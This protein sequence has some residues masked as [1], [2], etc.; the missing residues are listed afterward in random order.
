MATTFS[1]VVKKSVGRG[2]KT[3]GQKKA[4]RF[5]RPRSAAAIARCAERK[6]ARRNKQAASER[7]NKD[8]REQGLPT[9]WEIAKSRRHAARH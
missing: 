3:K 4:R 2:Q 1:D 6:L 5:N 9:P 8:L 7:V